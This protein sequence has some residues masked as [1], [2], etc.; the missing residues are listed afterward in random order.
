[1]RT[2]PYGKG[3]HLRHP[4]QANC[5][6]P[7]DVLL[8]FYCFH[9]Q[10]SQL[11][12]LYIVTKQICKLC[13]TRAQISSVD[14]LAEASLPI[15]N[16]FLP[17]RSC[18]SS[19][20][21]TICYY[22]SSD[23]KRIKLLL[24]SC[25]PSAGVLPPL[26][27]KVLLTMDHLRLR[28]ARPSGPSGKKDSK[29]QSSE[30]ELSVQPSFAGV[31]LEI[32]KLIYDHFLVVPE[33]SP[34]ISLRNK[35]DVDFRILH[36]SKKIREEAWH[37]FVH[38]NEWIQVIYPKQA[39]GSHLIDLDG[40]PRLSQHAIPVD[41][42]RKLVKS[43]TLSI[44]LVR[45]A[46]TNVSLNGSIGYNSAVFIFTKPAYF[47][48]TYRLATTLEYSVFALSFKL[49]STRQQT[50]GQ[51][52]ERTL[53]PL[54]LL[55]NA[56]K[57]VFPGNTNDRLFRHITAAM[58]SFNIVQCIPIAMS[59]TKLDKSIR[60]IQE[61]M[62]AVNEEGDHLHKQGMDLAAIKLYNLALDAHMDAVALADNADLSAQDPRLN[63]IK[64]LNT[65][66][67]IEVAKIT[68]KLNGEQK[69]ET[70][71]FKRTALPMLEEAFLILH[72][73][74]N[75]PGA[76]Q[77]QRRAAHIERSV[78]AA[79]LA[80]YFSTKPKGSFTPLNIYT[81]HRYPRSAPMLQ[82]G[83]L[84]DSFVAM[85]LSPD[86]PSRATAR[87]LYDPFCRKYTVRE[88]VP[89]IQTVGIP[90]HG[91]WRGDMVQLMNFTKRGVQ[92]L[93]GTTERDLVVMTVEEIK[94]M[95]EDLGI[96]GDRCDGLMRL[97]KA[98]YYTKAGTENL[99][100]EA[101]D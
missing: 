48:F 63:S 85:E 5:L 74:F 43:A 39:D 21:Y 1:M 35:L 82:F 26:N 71:N 77:A 92:P 25:R 59:K 22:R 58:T 49:N 28:Q 79:H 88:T 70:G 93:M 32:R 16:I 89:P 65:D 13:F 36:I 2:R 76:T 86:A 78:A 64:A 84:N 52:I 29:I 100:I 45:K 75:W 55:Q 17:D 50:Y 47:W 12:S 80:D 9:V 31:P 30:A 38:S 23:S 15:F 53:V 87:T 73:V 54:T 94:N 14:F 11:I 42:M 51:L 18:P 60:D 10:T 27:Q 67:C 57:V 34:G 24:T 69:D 41:R 61:Y 81:L 56:A 7:S 96:P 40:L 19:F 90:G 33:H 68:N 3:Q 44:R 98:G 46:A 62:V 72:H 95:K 91:I 20:A 8:C 99:P 4:D 66:V 97:L 83:A 6:G 101:L 37:H